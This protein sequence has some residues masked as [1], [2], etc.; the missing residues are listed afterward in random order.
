MHKVGDIIKVNI[1]KVKQNTYKLSK[2][3]ISKP[4]IV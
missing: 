1:I 4:D 2:E 3:T